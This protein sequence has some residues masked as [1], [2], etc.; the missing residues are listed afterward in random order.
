M[1]FLFESNK[2]ASRRVCAAIESNDDL[3]VE[4]LEIINGA[5][6]LYNLDASRTYNRQE[7]RDRSRWC[8]LLNLIL[9]PTSLSLIQ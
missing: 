6:N 8:G 7:L 2:D 1:K 4:F 9:I 5:D 3:K